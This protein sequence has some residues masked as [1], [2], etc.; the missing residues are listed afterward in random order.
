MLRSLLRIAR[1]CSRRCAAHACGRARGVGGSDRAAFTALIC[2]GT[3]EILGHADALR[4]S[5]TRRGG[6]PLTNGPTGSMAK[7]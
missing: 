3:S 4:T 6:S 7:A 2:K 5:R 1:S